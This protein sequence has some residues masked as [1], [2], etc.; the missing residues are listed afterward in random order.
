MDENKLSQFKKFCRYITLMILYHCAE[1]G[2]IF[3]RFDL[4]NDFVAQKMDF[5]LY[6]NYIKYCKFDFNFSQRI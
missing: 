6:Y 1:N 5:F 2:N 3:N 4:L